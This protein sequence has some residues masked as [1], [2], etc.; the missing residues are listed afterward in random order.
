MALLDILFRCGYKTDRGAFQPPTA[1]GCGRGTRTLSVSVSEEY[2]SG[3]CAGQRRRSGTGS[4]KAG[5]VLKKP[6]AAARYRNSCSVWPI[7]E[8]RQAAALV[9]AHQADDQVETVLL[10]LLRGSGLKG[11]GG[12]ALPFIQ[13]LSTKTIPLI[14]PHY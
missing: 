5:R 7:A 1:P 6:P 10:N 14:R 4:A 12:N 2:G 3:I 8:Q 13:P 11:L 9:V